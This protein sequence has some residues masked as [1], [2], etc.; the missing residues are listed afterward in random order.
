MLRRLKLDRNFSECEFDRLKPTTLRP[1][2]KHK[3][4]R[5]MRP[6][7]DII[8]SPNHTNSKRHAD[9]L[10]QILRELCAFNLNYTFQFSEQIQELNAAKRSMFFYDVTSRFTTRKIH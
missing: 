5:P 2:K 8:N 6:I 9:K 10:L 7:F 3:P 1:L 4:G